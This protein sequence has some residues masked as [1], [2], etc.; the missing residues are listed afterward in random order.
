MQERQDQGGLFHRDRRDAVGKDRPLIH[1]N[2]SR[3][4]RRWG[5]GG[6]N[7]DFILRLDDVEFAPLGQSLYDPIDTLLIPC[8]QQILERRRS[9]R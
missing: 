4:L 1:R 7:Q 9:G 2:L 5:V 8:R 3:G 6:G